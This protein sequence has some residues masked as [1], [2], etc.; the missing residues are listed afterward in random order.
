M[1]GAFTSVTLYTL[2]RYKSIKG[3]FGSMALHYFGNFPIY[4]MAINFLNLGKPTWT[5]IVGLYLGAYFILM[6]GI[7]AYFT[8]GK[9]SVMRFLW[10]Q[11]RCPECKQIYNPTILAFNSFNKRYEKCPHCKHWH[12]TGKDDQVK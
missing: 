1:H 3:I 7:L 9:F 2:Y 6:V 5:T 11:V 12:W 10:G 8:F 4:L